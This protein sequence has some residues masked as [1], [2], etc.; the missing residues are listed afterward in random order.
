MPIPSSSVCPLPHIDVRALHTSFKGR[1][2]TLPLL[3]RTHDIILYFILNQYCS[4]RKMCQG[5]YITYAY[6]LIPR[7][8]SRTTFISCHIDR[9]QIP[10]PTGF[11]LA[12]LVVFS[13]ILD[14]YCRCRMSNV[15]VKQK[16]GCTNLIVVC[17]YRS[18]Y[19]SLS[20][21]DRYKNFIHWLKSLVVLPL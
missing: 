17:L 12:V 16:I 18:A 20:G 13:S 11:P 5:D 19:P 14:Q 2:T 6:S 21:V 1:L 4:H 8:K 15:G 7:G 3:S 9:Y 10:P